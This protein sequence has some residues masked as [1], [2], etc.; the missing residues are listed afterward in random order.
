MMGVLERRAW[1]Y[2]GM[3]GTHSDLSVVMV[4][5]LLGKYSLGSRRTAKSKNPTTS[6]H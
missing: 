4:V 1:L 2:V 3:N 6:L 5:A